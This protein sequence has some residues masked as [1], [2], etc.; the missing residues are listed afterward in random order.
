M[1][2]QQ[3]KA[4]RERLGLS[5]DE[6]AERLGYVGAQRRSIVSKLESGRLRIS[7]AQPMMARAIRRL[8]KLRGRS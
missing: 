3:L 6:M 8:S 1:T 5:Q 4:L 2:P 7:P